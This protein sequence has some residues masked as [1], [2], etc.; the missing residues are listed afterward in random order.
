[1][2][3]ASRNRVSLFPSSV[4]LIGSMIGAGIFFLPG[5]FAVATDPLGA[6]VAWQGKSIR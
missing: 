2:A 6:I 1:M 3:A 4:L 5:A